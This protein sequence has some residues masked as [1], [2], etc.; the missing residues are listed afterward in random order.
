M[1]VE[2]DVLY[3]G[4][5]KC[6]AIHVPSGRVIGTEAPV[7]NGG[8]GSEFSPTDLMGA[9]LASCVM[10]VMGIVAQRQGLELRGMQARVVKE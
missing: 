2:M 4:S 9:A 1:S 5:L 6:R 10:T 8:T 3:D 7:D